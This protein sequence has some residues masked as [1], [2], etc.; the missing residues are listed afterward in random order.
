MARLLEPEISLVTSLPRWDGRPL[1]FAQ[2]LPTRRR[3]RGGL[4]LRYWN[5]VRMGFRQV[6]LEAFRLAQERAQ[7]GVVVLF[8]Q[9][10]GDSR[11][12]RELRQI[13]PDVPLVCI[14]KLSKLASG[15]AEEITGAVREHHASAVII[16]NLERLLPRIHWASP[17]SRI[18]EAETEVLRGIRTVISGFDHAT[19]AVLFYLMNEDRA[20]RLLK[21]GLVDRIEEVRP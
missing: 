13:E 16:D 21:E 6:A 12:Q 3:R 11:L 18:E 10:R 5:D 17:R 15:G 4:T 20:R 1:V 2:A 19:E 14:R 9:P 8:C 7:E